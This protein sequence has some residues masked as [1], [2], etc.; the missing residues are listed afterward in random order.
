MPT[1]FNS[2]VTCP[3]PRPDALL[4]L[5]CLPFAGGGTTAFRD[6]GKLLGTAVEVCP[7]Q[8]PGRE[9]RFSEPAFKDAPALARE[10]AR[11]LPPYTEAPFAIFGH[12]M[13]ALLAFEL[14]RVL[15]AEGWRLPKALILGAHRPAHLPRTRETF[16]NLD[17]QTFIKKLQRFGGFPEEV[18]AS[19]E[20]M[21][22]LMPTLKADFT[23]CDTYVYTEQEPLNCPIHVFVGAADPEAPPAVMDG[24]C[25]HSSVNTQIHVFQTGHFFIRS[26]LERVVDILK[27]ILPISATPQKQG[28]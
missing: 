21:Q 6:W 8:L 17:D 15:Q 23:L 22:L 10:L 28:K 5:F 24:W 16:Y 13:G 11:Q 14:T 19:E 26:E 1:K 27:T 20:L 25:R 18:L 3:V 2:W 4:S 7:I 9:S 12:S